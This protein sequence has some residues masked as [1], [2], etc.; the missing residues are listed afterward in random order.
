ML[1]LTPVVATS[2]RLAL[3]WGLHGVLTKDPENLADMVRK[4][5]RISFE[6]GFAKTREGVV[7]TAGVPLGSPGA[8]NMVRIA[9]LGEDGYPLAEGR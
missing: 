4:A 3:V 6:E 7:V 2:R 8:T 9:V 5:C 1:A